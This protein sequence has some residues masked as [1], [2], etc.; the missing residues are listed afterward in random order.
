ML[1]CASCQL[2]CAKKR[3]PGVVKHNPIEGKQGSLTQDKYRFGNLVPVYKFLFGLTGQLLEGYGRESKN[4]LCHG[5]TVFKYA[6]SGIILVENQVSLG[7][8]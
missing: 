6:A 3:S 2:A 4:N 1:E 5:G 7:S 8:G